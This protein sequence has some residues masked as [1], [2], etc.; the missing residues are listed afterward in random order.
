MTLL[1]A[2]KASS[3]GISVLYEWLFRLFATILAFFYALIPN[4]AIAIAL[5]TLAVMLI[6]TPLTIKGTRQMV[7]MQ[8]LQPEMQKLRTKYK[9]DRQRMNEEIMALYKE[10]GVPMTGGCITQLLQWPAFLVLYQVIRGLTNMTPGKHP[11]PNPRYVAT[12]TRLYHDLVHA[13][14]HLV[15]F[16]MDLS[17]S[18]TSHHSSTL[19]A[20][21]YWGILGVTVLLGYLQMQQ[22]NKR[23]PAVGK[24]ASQMQSMQ[25][26]MPLMF[27]AIYIVLPALLNVYFVVS[28][29]YR[30]M[31]QE[32]MFRYDPVL[33]YS[34]MGERARRDA[35]AAEAGK[36]LKAPDGVAAT[37]E[38]PFRRVTSLLKPPELGAG[39]QK[40][41]GTNGSAGKAA[42]GAR[43]G[44]ETPG[45][46]GSARADG[47]RPAQSRPRRA[48]G[49]KPEQKKAAPDE[50]TPS[51]EARPHPRA[52]GKRPRRPR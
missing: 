19:A 20:L 52:Q 47:G 29:L 12:S 7:A 45:T 3:P 14:G 38:S 21:P 44:R 11:V 37:K 43:E 34:P 2:A 28:S 33:S 8:R 24:M 46:T 5:L 50:D 15:S 41:A 10:Q 22:I 6:M 13:N 9:D 48:S 27:G 51:A 18:A 39:P 36:P 4:Y 35:A 42:P 26:I 30:I 1:A 17:K 31:V 25:K 32:L 49:R 16:G 23:N 40:E